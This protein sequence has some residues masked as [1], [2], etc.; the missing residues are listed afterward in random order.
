MIDERLTGPR[1]VVVHGSATAVLL[2][3]P[4]P[5]EEINA[6]FEWAATVGRLGGRLVYP[7]GPIVSS[8]SS[9]SG[10]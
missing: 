3:R 2:D 5:V 1:I 9:R 8:D 6:A 10:D 4:A 7:I